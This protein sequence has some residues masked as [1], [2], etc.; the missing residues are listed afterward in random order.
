MK[1]QKNLNIFKWLFVLLLILIIGLGGYL[2]AQIHS[3][4][5]NDISKIESRRVIA[6]NKEPV[7]IQLNKKQVNALSN[8]YLNRIQKTKHNSRINYHFVVGN[9]AYVYGNINVLNNQIG[10]ILSLKPYLLPNG[11]V[12]LIADHLQMGALK[13]PPKFVISYVAKHY[14]IPKWVGLDGHNAQVILDLN[15]INNYHGISYQAKKIDMSGNGNFDFKI[16]IPKSN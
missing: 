8:Y 7:D 5:S 16:L 3:S 4:D 10:Y 13:L 14:R 6:K 9:E 12:K 15:Q 1:K 11:N 2:F